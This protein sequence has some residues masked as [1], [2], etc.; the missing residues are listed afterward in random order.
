MRGKEKERAQ[1][2]AV[3]PGVG[4]SCQTWSPKHISHPQW[5]HLSRLGRVT[6]SHRAVS[7]HTVASN[8]SSC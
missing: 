3:R 7:R 2:V 8:R 1:A 4:H 6:I 5:H